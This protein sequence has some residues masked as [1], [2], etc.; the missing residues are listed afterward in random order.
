MSNRTR[1]SDSAS[2]IAGRV[3]DDIGPERRRDLALR[4]GV[5]RQ[6]VHHWRLSGIPLDR[7]HAVADYLGMHPSDLRPDF[8]R[9]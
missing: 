4:L 7:V 9:Q 6:A 3:L 8:F 5:T 1:P 2:I